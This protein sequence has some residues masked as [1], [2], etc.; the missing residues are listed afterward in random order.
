MKSKKEKNYSRKTKKP[1]VQNNKVKNVCLSINAKI[2]TSTHNPGH[3]ILKLYHVLV[4]FWFTTSKVNLDIQFNKFGRR[5]TSQFAKQL[6]TQNLKKLGQ[7]TKISNLDGAIVQCPV[8][9]SEIKIW[10]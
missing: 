8:F 6:K 7:I 10:Q 4:Q 9:P 3:N 1:A 2:A 5:V